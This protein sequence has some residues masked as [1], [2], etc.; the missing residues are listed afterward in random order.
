MSYYNQIMRGVDQVAP[1]LFSDEDF[2]TSIIW[3]VHKGATW[4]V[5]ERKN[6]ETYEEHS[7]TVMKLMKEYNSMSTRNLP[8][9]IGGLVTGQTM[10]IARV[11]VDV[12]EGY[13]YKDLIVDDQT[14][15]IE[16][17]FTVLNK[18]LLIDVKG[19]G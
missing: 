15:G 1:K 11:D 10:Y 18:F 4:N 14:Y 16:R 5:E 3:K 17:Y 9:G 7:V 19:P 2:T 6:D 8:A 12:P 13:S